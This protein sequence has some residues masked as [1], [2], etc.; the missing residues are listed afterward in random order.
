MVQRLIFLL[1]ASFCLL[2][3]LQ[4]QSLSLDNYLQQVR[5]GNEDYQALDKGSEGAKLRSNEAFFVTSPSLYGQASYLKDEKLPDSPVQPNDI[6][7][8][9]YTLG[10]AEQFP[11]GLDAKFSYNYGKYNLNGA[12]PQVI[13]PGYNAFYRVSPQ[14]E[15]NVPLFKNLF[16]T[17]TRAK[18][19]ILLNDAQAKEYGESFK[20]KLLLAEA[21]SVYWKLSLARSLVKS[22]KDNLDRAEKMTAWSTRRKNL[23]L[24]DEASFLQADANH[25]LRQLEFQAA[26]DDERVSRRRFNSLR[27]IAIDSVSENL[28]EPTGLITN[29][30]VPANFTERED[31]MSARAALKEK[32]AASELAKQKFRPSLDL[33]GLYAWNGKSAGQATTMDEGLKGDRPTYAVGLR[34]SMPLDVIALNKQQHGYNLEEKEAEL[35]LS[36]KEFESIRDWEDIKDRFVEGRDRFKVLTRI[37]EA[38][39]KKLQRERDLQLRGRSTLFQVLQYESDYATSQIART[40]AQV[41]LLSLYAVLK[42]YPGQTETQTK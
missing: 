8:G 42:T 29:L 41:E 26:V 3:K 22:A 35:Q 7:A 33:F 30:N 14:I 32:K 4:A 36:R 11:F 1:L 6:R 34:F 40:R 17:E 21:E 10:I 23:G 9:T 38:Q 13:P 15:V 5:Q 25:E 2:P 37:E 27:G 12:F 31:L 20:A 18:R 19:D 24:A 16:G 28:A 39:R